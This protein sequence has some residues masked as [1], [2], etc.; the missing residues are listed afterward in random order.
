[1]SEHNIETQSPED[2]FNTAVLLHE[3]EKFEDAVGIYRELL[4]HFPSAALLH[5]NIALA[6]SD[7]G[8][9]QT[10]HSHFQQAY[11]ISPEDPSVQFSL[12]YSHKNMGEIAQACSLYE[13]LLESNG[14]Q[15]D[16]LY[17]LANC[18]KD[19]S[20]NRAAIELYRK[21]LLLVPDHKSAVNNLAFI[22][23]KENRIED[24]I[25]CYKKVLEIDSENI[26]AQYIL[27]V[28]TGSNEIECPPD[29]YIQEVF[30]SYSDHY[31]KSLVQELEYCVPE[32]I[33]SAFASLELPAKFSQVLDLG[34][35]SGL[36]AETFYNIADCFTGVDLSSKMLHLAAQ[37]NLYHK[38]F[39]APIEEFL[40]TTEQH[41]DLILAADVFAYFG[42]LENVF[43]KAKK[44][45][46]TDTVFAFSAEVNENEEFSVRKSGRFAH[47]VN[48][49]EN[50]L[51]QSGWKLLFKEETGIRKERGEWI[52]GVIAVA[53]PID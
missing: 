40:D 53:V 41:Y 32:K 43:I 35:G 19:S 39:C 2:L 30:D 8:E 17:N 6:Y 52:Q 28:L 22:L 5:L 3:Q 47:S 13:S 36:A 27:S 29:S 51:L 16:V 25:D 48:Y 38:L 42:S 49:I 45:A 33:Q 20:N 7:M 37:K 26:S 34:C 15:P 44:A 24:A 10:A 46:H 31:D 18:Y 14:E 4:T 50:T 23:H 12:A 9:N 1:M 21:V 11:K